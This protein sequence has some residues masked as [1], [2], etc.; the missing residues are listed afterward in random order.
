MTRTMGS[1]VVNDVPARGCRARRRMETVFPVDS[2]HGGGAGAA[3]RDGKRSTG[4][5]YNNNSPFPTVNLRSTGPV[6][7]VPE[8][9]Q[10]QN[11]P[12]HR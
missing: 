10:Q 12:A 4:R 6:S 8:K 5:L 9:D 11:D 2:V 1:I 7:P 3:G